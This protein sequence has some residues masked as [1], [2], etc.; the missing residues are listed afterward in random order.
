MAAGAE[1]PA[2]TLDGGAPSVGEALEPAP[3]PAAAA[4]TA[5]PLLLF[6]RLGMASR[7]AVVAGALRSLH[8]AEPLLACLRLLG[9]SVLIRQ[10]SYFTITQ[11]IL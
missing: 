5:N 9:C 3:P 6:E 8:G 4:T 2:A 7:T 11:Q 10:I 1:M